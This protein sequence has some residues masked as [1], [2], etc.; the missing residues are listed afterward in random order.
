MEMIDPKD[1]KPGDEVYVIYRN[2]HTPTVSNIKPA[3]I[4]QHPNDPGQNALF[5]YET[6]HLIE[7]NDA[8]FASE[9]AAQEAFDQIY[10]DEPDE[11]FI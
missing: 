6:Y 11:T 3:E 5:L 7:E 8:L 2:P 4:V 1:V 10:S 9:Q